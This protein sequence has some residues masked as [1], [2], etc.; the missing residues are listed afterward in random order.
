MRK[1]YGKEAN[2]IASYEKYAKIRDEHGYT[3]YR[4]AKETGIGAAT[5][6]DWKNGLTKP[7]IDKLFLIAVLF[8]VKIEDFCEET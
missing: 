8:N 2:L 5:L 6:S 3:D 7:K 1:K 4:V